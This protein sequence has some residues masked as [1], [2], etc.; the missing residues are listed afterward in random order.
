[1][2]SFSI[3]HWLIL[4]FILSIHLVPVWRIVSKAGYSGAFS[5]LSCVP[6]LNVIMLWVFAFSTWP[7]Q[8]SA[9]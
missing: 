2:A 3:W 5:L 8:K 7:N 4:S 9:Q 1:M 6:V